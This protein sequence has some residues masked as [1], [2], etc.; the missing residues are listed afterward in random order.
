MSWLNRAQALR[1]RWPFLLA[2][3]LL[4]VL[5][6]GTF[7]YLRLAQTPPAYR[8]ISPA[9]DPAAWTFYLSDGTPAQPDEAGVFHLPA[10]VTILCCVTTLPQ[11]L[12]DAAFL[13]VS[14]Q[15]MDA[16]L[17]LNGAPVAQLCGSGG[18]SGPAS[19]SGYCTLRQAAGGELTLA[20]RFS[21]A[22]AEPS[23][24]ALPALTLYAEAAAFVYQGVA[25][26]AEAALPA[27]VFLAAA[28][29]LLALFLFQMWKDR[30]DW[31]LLLLA[32]AFLFLCL[33]QTVTY[34][35]FTVVYFQTPA[36]LWLTQIAP[37]LSL[38]WLLWYH[39]G[40]RVR[41]FAWPAPLLLTAV[42]LSM[43]VAR[44]LDLQQ[45][46]APMNLFQG[47][48]LPLAMLLFLAEGVWEALRGS[49]WHRRVLEV[50]G[51]LLAVAAA[52]A[53]L[54]RLES[55]R[56]PGSIDTIRSGLGFGSCFQLLDVWNDVLIAACFLLAVYHFI[57]GVARRD[58]ALQTLSL[59]KRYAEEN[60]DLLR[61]SLDRTRQD[62]HEFRHHLEA[63]GA[64]AQARDWERLEAYLNTLSS[65]QEDAPLRYSDNVLVN[66]IVTPRLNRAREAGVEV[67]AAIQVPER[68]G[69]EDA[70]L[71][72]FLTNLLDNAL[73]AAIPSRRERRRLSLRV[74][75]H[76]ERLFIA[77]ENTFDG[78]LIFREDG[79]IGSSKK[80]EGHGYGL[81]T[82]QRVAEKYNSVLKIS[83]EDGYFQVKTN[84][85][86][87][88]C[89]L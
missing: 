2:L 4:L 76:N 86:L 48:I 70:D 31:A 21:Q 18:E 55:G 59:Q 85:A 52:G 79:S 71:S 13:G 9:E 78:P 73:E 51:G 65:Q 66:A 36:V 38:L 19:L 45:F 1:R 50:S 63:L 11:D 82:M 44:L 23:L 67:Q 84:L 29:F 30:T 34:A 7:L 57:Q 3:A 14:A 37:T 12:T 6:A 43:A 27:G 46:A 72:I 88:Q 22:G 49:A 56:W 8:T 47:Q 69:I 87:H 15:D 16:A 77:C 39:T 17:L 26:G 25:A 68:L 64:L 60:A 80:E 10:G 35:L 28:L 61:E 5:V 75:V 62:R 33:E 58:V 89:R 42:C 41:K 24:A 53:A 81:E 40:E 54:F 20:V 83:G 74:G 32:L